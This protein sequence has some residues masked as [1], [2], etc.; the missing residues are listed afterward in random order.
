[1]SSKDCS[2]PE[3]E[4]STKSSTIG[5]ITGFQTV[6]IPISEKPVMRPLK[7]AGSY[8]FKPWEHGVFSE[9]HVVKYAKTFD[10]TL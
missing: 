5:V 8:K 10:N 3:R 2:H 1:M 4:V 6:D 7:G 9:V